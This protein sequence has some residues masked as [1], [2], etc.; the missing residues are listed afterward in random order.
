MPVTDAYATAATYRA[1]LG[2]NDA[3]IDA[4]I[5]DDLTAVSRYLDWKCERF[6]TKDSAV[7]ARLYLPSAYTDSLIVDDIAD[8]AGLVIKVDTNRDGSFT[9][10]TA[11]ASTDYQLWPLNAATGPEPKPYTKI[12]IPPWSTRGNF[13]P[14]YLVQV[15]AIG[16]WPAVPKALERADVH[17]TGILRL[18]TPRATERTNEAMD[19]VFAMSD[20]AKSI[21]GQL[22][23]A[24]ARPTVFS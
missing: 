22:V 1:L 12:V 9:T 7:V 14:G 11:F 10:E 17:L 21:I 18:E 5:L 15:T 4:Q 6:F 3:S 24:Y 16:G 23:A 20:T 2:K 13:M 19:K 8:T